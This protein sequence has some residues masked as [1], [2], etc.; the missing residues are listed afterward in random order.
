MSD[1][2]R[3]LVFLGNGKVG[4][5]DKPIPEPGPNEAVVR[6]TAA[7]ICTSDVHT[8]RGAITIPE[9]RTLGHESIG[10]VHRLGSAVTGF[11]VGQRVAVGAITPCFQCGP[12]QRGFTSQ[13]QGMLGGYKFTTQRDGNMAEYFLVNDAT[14]NLTP[15]PA[16]VT[17][18]SAVYV[19]DML[20]TG[21]GGAENTE[22]RLGETVAVFA[23]GPVGLAATIGC[24]LMGAG[25]IIA[26]EG[27]PERQEL[28]RRF[29][30]DIVLDPAAGDV[31]ARIMD[32]TDGVGVDA[33]VEAFGFPETFEAAIRATKPGGRIS[34]IGY[35]GENPAPLPIPLEPFGMGMS[36]KKIL[37]SLCPGGSERLGRLLRLIGN[38]RIDPTPMTTH[39][40]SFDAVEDA[41]HLMESKADR[42]VKPL[43]RFA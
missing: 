23:Q 2:M 24:R 41:F 19:T 30:A 28:A 38:G 12:C 26:V 32:L 10:V 15:I 20:S 27:R 14:A 31:V 43:I 33:A 21:F 4:V 22:L 25:Q 9:G 16:G 7:L 17:D 39:E 6:T 34:N 18:E 8:V 29:G 42:I 37:T 1:T 36:D 40:F 35:H 3:A 13:C 11:A 5:V